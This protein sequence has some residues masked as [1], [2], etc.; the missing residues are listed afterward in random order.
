MKNIKREEGIEI[1][2]KK[3]KIYNNGVEKNI[4]F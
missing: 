2:G 4:K 3:I 1:L